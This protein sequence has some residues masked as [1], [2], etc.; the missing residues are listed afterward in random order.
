LISNIRPYFKKIWKATTDGTRSGDVLSFRT[1]DKRLLQNYLYIVLQS[2]DFFDYVTSTS[3][4]TKMP[5][6]DKDAILNYEFKLPS[7]DDQKRL[8]DSIINLEKRFY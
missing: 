2:D 8:S 6:G 4:G 5:R 1:K 3:K 7:L